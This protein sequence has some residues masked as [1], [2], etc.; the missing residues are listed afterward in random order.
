MKYSPI[1]GT[2]YESGLTAKAMYDLADSLLVKYATRE[3]AL[4]L[5]REPT[6]GTE[7]L[8]MIPGMRSELEEFLTSYFFSDLDPCIGGFEGIVMRPHNLP[9]KAS[10]MKKQQAK[11]LED[12][13]QKAEGQYGSREAAKQAVYEVFQKL[14]K[15]WNRLLEQIPYLMGMKG[16]NLRKMVAKDAFN[17]LSMGIYFW[18]DTAKIH[19]RQ[20]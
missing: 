19:M 15:R 12:Y 1:T 7:K 17:N 9:E 20:L 14:E 11:E 13:V 10:E 16:K 4:R 8:W 6:F 3:D 5:K 18:A 2:D